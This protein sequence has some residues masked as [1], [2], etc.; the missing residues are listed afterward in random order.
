MIRGTWKTDLND[1]TWV[2]TNESMYDGMQIQAEKDLAAYRG[3]RLVFL[4]DS[5]M[6]KLYL[7]SRDSLEKCSDKKKMG[8]CGNMEYLLGT[9]LLNWTAPNHSLL[10][11]PF[12]Y[13]L[14]NPGCTDMS[15]E[16]TQ[17]V[18]CRG[19]LG[20]RTNKQETG[21]EWELEYLG[22]EFARDVEVQ[23]DRIRTT[24]EAA[25]HYMCNRSAPR[26]SAI[27]VNT[28]V[29]DVILLNHV[30][31]K[32]ISVASNTTIDFWA[33]IYENNV[34]QYLGMLVRSCKSPIIFVMT[35][36][37]RDHRGRSNLVIVEFNRR[38]ARLAEDMGLYIVDQQ[39]LMGE[40]AD[41]LYSDNVHLNKQGGVYYRV[42]WAYMTKLLQCISLLRQP[43]SQSDP[44][45]PEI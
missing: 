39:Q 34:L 37:M 13:G 28:G 22:V 6:A 3:G 30:L 24:Q 17:D 41:Q 45:K 20:N 25:A 42:L 15:S 9:K 14:S 11:G 35:S 23:T 10:E 44:D 7:K 29:H 18:L 31:E 36:L 38:A 21:Y 19:K 4:G 8:R 33:D 26:P 27:V 2:S 5:Q 32:Q 16:G 43:L 40:G 1:F 12:V